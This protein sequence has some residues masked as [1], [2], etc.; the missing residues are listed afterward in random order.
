MNEIRQ[1]FD[2]A[3]FGPIKEQ[4]RRTPFD[5]SGYIARHERAFLSPRP[6]FEAAIVAGLTALAAYACAHEER[7]GSKLAEDGVLGEA[8]LDALRG[9]RAMLNGELGNLDG[10]FLDAAFCNLHRTAG[11]EGE[12]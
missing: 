9:F 1:A 7:Y 4:R 8:W 11:F 5:T 6:G 3:V 10:G 2:A 12:L